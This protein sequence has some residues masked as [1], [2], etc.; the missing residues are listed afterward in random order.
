MSAD[1]LALDA[2][3]DLP[4]TESRQPL[5]WRGQDSPWGSTPAW[6][7]ERLQQAGLAPEAD[8]ADPAA[9]LQRLAQG[10]R[11]LNLSGRWRDEAVRVPHPAGPTSIERGCA[12][13]LGVQTLAVHLIGWSADGG[14]WLQ[15]RAASKAE[16]P[17]LW[18][19]LVGG[20]VSAAEGPTLA[21]KRETWEEAGLELDALGPQRPGP[22]LFSRRPVSDAQGAGYLQE[23]L[24]TAQ[25]TLPPGLR[26]CNQDGE[27]QA[28]AL[29]RPDEVRAGIARGEFTLDAARLLL[30]LLPPA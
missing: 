1:L 8:P 27:V 5:R 21:L 29:W 19:T 16:D 30:R 4:P 13:V 10:L 20:M 3:A 25:V 6:V 9:H 7:L 28:F 24:L 2:A 17:L 26:P 11:E 14:L 18:D 15:Q 22:E 23:R 12:R